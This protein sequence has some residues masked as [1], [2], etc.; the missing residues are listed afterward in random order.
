MSH[1]SDDAGNERGGVSGKRVSDIGAL[2]DS[3]RTLGFEAAKTGAAL[4][5][6]LKAANPESQHLGGIIDRMKS[7]SRSTGQDSTLG[8]LA[9]HITRQQQSIESFKNSISDILNSHLLKS[10][11]SDPLSLP[12][13]LEFQDFDVP[14]NPVVETNERLERI[15]KR[16][17]LMQGIAADAAEIA[18]GLQAA[19]AEFLQKFEKAAADNDRAAGRA[20]WLGGAA[21]IVAV[22]MTAIQIGY[23][24]YRR[25]PSD[26][27]EVQKAL[28]GLRE[29]L[30]ALQEAQVA[31]LERL[32]E[33][34]TSSDS[35]TTAAMTDIFKLLSQQAVS[36]AALEPSSE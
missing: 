26:A 1:E 5:D 19:A 7:V 31:A 36:S 10:P 24:E 11:V 9:E 15:E 22:V 30:S 14:Q 23:A 35:E 33:V 18:T 17:E 20:I 21:V 8:G 6:A 3:M 13:P 4:Q 16:F 27:P 28:G 29:D 2:S 32:G 34:I 12:N 25:E